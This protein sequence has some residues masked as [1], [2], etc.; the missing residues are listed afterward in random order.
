MGQKLN[1]HQLSDKV[2]HDDN[3]TEKL[4]ARFA[5]PMQVVAAVSDHNLSA[6]S[7][8]DIWAAIET[9]QQAINYLSDRITS[10]STSGV[11][12]L[13]TEDGKHLITENNELI[14]II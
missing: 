10:G 3:I 14:S 7:H 6:T 13:I 2:I 12:P 5:T 8:A 9:L 11:I 1:I 4:G